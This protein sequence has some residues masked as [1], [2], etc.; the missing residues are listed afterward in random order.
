MVESEIHFDML[1]MFTQLWLISSFR[2]V[3]PKLTQ[4]HPN[5]FKLCMEEIEGY[6]EI[7]ILN[8]NSHTLPNFF[9]NFILSIGKEGQKH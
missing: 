1:L 7:I 2:L 8:I 9:W 6:Y 4:M 3:K 5:E